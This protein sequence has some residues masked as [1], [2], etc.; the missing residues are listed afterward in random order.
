MYESRYITACHNTKNPTFVY[1]RSGES[2]ARY[3]MRHDRTLIARSWQARQAP[4]PCFEKGIRAL[5]RQASWLSTGRV[6][7]FRSITVA[8]QRWTLTSFHLHAL[9]S[10]LTGRLDSIMLST[11]A[12]GLPT[13]FPDQGWQALGT[14]HDYSI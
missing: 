5:S 12:P 8:A 3:Q 1:R 13:V 4:P 14:T 7:M 11:F 10:G 2:L 9:A 6:W